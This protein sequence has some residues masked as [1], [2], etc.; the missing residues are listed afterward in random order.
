MGIDMEQVKLSNSEYLGFYG[1][2]TVDKD[3][4]VSEFQLISVSL[5]YNQYIDMESKS[6]TDAIEEYKGFRAIYP[7]ENKSIVNGCSSCGG[8]VRM[9]RGF[10]NM[11]NRRYMCTYCSISA[12]GSV[13]MSQLIE[14]AQEKNRRIT[15]HFCRHETV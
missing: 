2:G 9:D 5:C 14:F 1:M 8:D 10:V 6:M 12:I 11:K 3:G 7:P 15:G 13:R 4:N